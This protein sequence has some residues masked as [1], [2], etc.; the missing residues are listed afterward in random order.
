VPDPKDLTS[1]VAQVT[2]AYLSRHQVELSLLPD[3]IRQIR[4]SLASNPTEV[5]P[6]AHGTPAAQTSQSPAVPIIESV[7]PDYLICLEDGKRLKVLKRH[8]RSRFGLSPEEYRTKWGLPDDYPMVAPNYAVTRSGI[9][10]EQRFGFSTVKNLKKPSAHNVE[11]ALTAM[12]SIGDAVVCTDLQC[13]ITFM[14]SVAERLTGWDAM[15]ATGKCF[16]EV[17]KLQERASR[18]TIYPARR[19]IDQ[20]KPFVAEVGTM[21]LS[22]SGEELDVG[23][24][25]API[26]TLA[27]EIIGSVMIFHDLTRTPHAGPN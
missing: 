19:C 10:K 18:T 8:L 21:L 4:A 27:G 13:A 1:L 3:L 9:A 11:F 17:F 15:Q 6:A 7:T 2:A 16:I 20:A 23:F 14:N 26:R 22:K 12:R 5:P 25:A 24:S